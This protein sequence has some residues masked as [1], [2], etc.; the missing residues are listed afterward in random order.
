M[1]VKHIHSYALERLKYVSVVLLI[2]LIVFISLLSYHLS[3]QGAETSYKSEYQNL[4]T[5][6]GQIKN[7]IV[8]SDAAISDWNQSVRKKHEFRD[9]IQVDFSKVLINK[10]EEKYRIKGMNINLSI[11]EQRLDF[12]DNKFVNIM[13]SDLSLVFL[14]Y[15]DIDAYSFVADLQK[16][17]PGYVQIKNVSFVG[18]NEINEEVLAGLQRGDKND[19]VSIKVELLWQDLADKPEVAEK[20]KIKRET[21]IKEKGSSQPTVSQSN[22]DTTAPTESA[23]TSPSSETSKV[24]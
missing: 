5:Q 20:V 22:P 11:P 9:G 21:M 1:L 16:E 14:A 23:P 3:N 13:Y 8:L 18:I 2:V 6:V 12:A 24:Q 10:L 17:L 19:I 7:Q 15:T 4:Q